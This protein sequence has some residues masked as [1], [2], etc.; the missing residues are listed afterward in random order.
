MFS[1]FRDA[2]FRDLLVPGRPVVLCVRVRGQAGPRLRPLRRRLPR[3]RGH[4]GAHQEG[5]RGQQVR[6]FLDFSVIVTWFFK[7]VRLV[8]K[9]L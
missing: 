9:V 6:V 8:D 4:E 7:V 1:P 2:P 5:P 3:A